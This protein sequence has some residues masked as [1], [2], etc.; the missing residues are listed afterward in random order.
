[1]KMTSE[2]AIEALVPIWKFKCFICPKTL[3][4]NGSI[5]TNASTPFLGCMLPSL[6]PALY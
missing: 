4:K 5:M 3:N 2:E 6:F 1:M